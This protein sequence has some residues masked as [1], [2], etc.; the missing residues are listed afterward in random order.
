MPMPASPRESGAILI[1]AVLLMT[2]V[3][4]FGIA[5]AEIST[6]MYGQTTLSGDRSKAHA[7]ADGGAD[8]AQQYLLANPSFRGSLDTIDVGEGTCEVEISEVGSELLIESLGTLGSVPVG[9]SAMISL[10]STLVLDHA[11]S[12]DGDVTIE[13]SNVSWGNGLA[14]TGTYSEVGTANT[15]GRRFAGA[16]HRGVG[17]LTALLSTGWPDQTFASGAVLTGELEGKTTVFGNATIEGPFSSTGV[18]V[19]HGDLVIHG[20]GQPVKLLMINN[21]NTLNVSGT[22]TVYDASPL[23]LTGVATVLRTTHFEGSTLRSN[24]AWL[25]GDLIFKGVNAELSLSQEVREDPPASISGG[26]RVYSIQELWRRNYAPTASRSGNG[27]T[28]DSDGATADAAETS[29]S[30]WRR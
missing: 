13:G 14:H 17:F 2:A 15:H 11:V 10:D 12:A 3:L 21:K 5:Y 29:T 20:N 22:L 28:L 30:W 9:V 25:T 16:A 18:L 1:L 4:V 26:N 8:Y 23:V 24:G 7:I 19:V 6:L 27:G